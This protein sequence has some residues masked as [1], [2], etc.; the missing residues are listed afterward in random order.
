MTHL[1]TCAYIEMETYWMY[2]DL[3][4][5]IICIFPLSHNNNDNKE[6]LTSIFRLV[7]LHISLNAYI[8]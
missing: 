5:Y 3:T 4:P 7:I 8:I 1:K 6:K 2:M